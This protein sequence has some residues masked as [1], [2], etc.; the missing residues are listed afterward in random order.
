MSFPDF[1]QIR[2]RWSRSVL[3]DLCQCVDDLPKFAVRCILSG[4]P[5]P[6]FEQVSFWRPIID[7]GVL[8]ETLR[9]VVEEVTKRLH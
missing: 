3:T 9:V 4:V 7:D 8:G 5:F 2:A 6:A 1:G